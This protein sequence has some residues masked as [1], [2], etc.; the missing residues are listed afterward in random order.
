MKIIRSS[1]K[2]NNTGLTGCISRKP[3]YRGY[4]VAARGFLTAEMA[5]KKGAPAEA[6]AP[7]FPKR[8]ES[9]IAN[10]TTTAT[11]TNTSPPY[12]RCRVKVRVGYCRVPRTR[13]VKVLAVGYIV[14]AELHLGTRKQSKTQ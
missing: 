12:L 6:D 5:K 3:L 14:H 4:G 8:Y 13:V 11:D 10:A 2:N 9:K 7:K 1:Q